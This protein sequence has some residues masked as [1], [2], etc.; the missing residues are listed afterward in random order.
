[1]KFSQ[2]HSIDLNNVGVYDKKSFFRLGLSSFGQKWWVDENASLDN[3]PVCACFSMYCYGG[4]WSGYGS[5]CQK[6]GFKT[7]NKERQERW[8]QIKHWRSRCGTKK[9]VSAVTNVTHWRQAVTCN[10][11]TSYNGWLHGSTLACS[12]QKRGIRTTVGDP[13]QKLADTHRQ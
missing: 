6:T 3:C 5:N 1:M 9:C 4:R 7:P 2:N 10:W 11:V 13:R 8:G 12:M